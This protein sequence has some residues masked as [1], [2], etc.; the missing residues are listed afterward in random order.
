[1]LGSLRNLVRRIGNASQP[2]VF[3]VI[4]LIF[5]YALFRAGY[6]K[7]NN[8]DFVADNF[9]KIGIPMSGINAIIVGVLEAVGGLLIMLGLITRVAAAALIVVLLVALVTAHAAEA[10]VFFSNPGSLV[11]AA[12]VPYLAVLFVLF[13]V[14]PGS[15]SADHMFV[16]GKA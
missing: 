6:W 10:K 7:L 2:Y 16:K 3:L 14:G 8:L 13:A 15:I 12:P 11:A 5:G 4:R 9:A 1:M